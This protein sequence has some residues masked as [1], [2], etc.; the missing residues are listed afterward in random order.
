ME[1]EN[2]FQFKWKRGNMIGKGAFGS[3]FQAMLS[4]GNKHI[5]I[6][7]YIINDLRP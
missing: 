1:N 3:V 2:D 4:T 6:Y 7:T 5:Y